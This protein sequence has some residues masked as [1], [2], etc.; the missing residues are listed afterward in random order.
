MAL[1]TRQKRVRR[2]RGMGSAVIVLLGATLLSAAPAALAGSGS[3]LVLLQISPTSVAAGDSVSFSV[4]VKNEANPQ[5]LGSANLTVPS[6]FAVTSA[7]AGTVVNGVVE[8]RNLAL[9]PGSSV[10]V[11]VNANAPCAGGANAWAVVAKQANDFSGPP[12]NNFT[13][14]TSSTGLS[15]TVSGNCHLAFLS[16]PADAVVNG[17][18]STVPFTANGGAVQVEVLDGNN[19]L[20][21]NSTAPV[22]LSLS[23]TSPNEGQGAVLSGGAAIDASGGIASFN[24]L[25]INVHGVY[26][27]LASS[28]TAGITSALSMP[29]GIWDDDASCA[30]G[31]SCNASINVKNSMSTDIQGL[32][33]GGGFLSLSLGEDSLSCGDTFNHAPSVTTVSAFGYSAAQPKTVTLTI[34]K[35]ALKSY[36]NSGLS[37]WAVCY[38]SPNE[39]TTASGPA[40]FGNGFFTGLLADC[41][42]AFPAPCVQSISKD[43]A[44]DVVEVV[45]V[46]A[47]D[48]TF[49]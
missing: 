6:G 35:A 45:S 20:I 28:T 11:T 5:S 47:G 36:P 19:Q 46:P 2:V 21:T 31:Q 9:A 44:N 24:T 17:T 4:T 34:F 39:F 3:K 7:S 32:A 40:P 42:P 23:A 16:M 43:P 30:N 25:S 8:L 10:T 41:G 14:D 26:V 13:V 27:L 49:H 12:G 18:I 38:A 29:F 1:L 15:T 37:F 22:S 48:P 33:G